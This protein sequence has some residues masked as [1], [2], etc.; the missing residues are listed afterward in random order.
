MLHLLPIRF[1]CA[2]LLY[3]LAGVG[4]GA[5]DALGLGSFRAAHTHLLAGGFFTLVIMGAMYQLL[6]TIIG[7]QLRY[8]RVAEAQFLLVNAGFLLLTYSFLTAPGMLTLSGALLFL[9]FLLFAFVIL[10]TCLSVP[11]FHRRSIAIWFFLAA[12]VYLLA[13]SGYALVS[14]LGGMEFNLPTHAHL[15]AAGFIAMTNFGGL[16]E[17]FPMLSLRQLHSRRLG[18]VHFLI[19]VLSATGMFLSFTGR[20]TLFY[21]SSALFLAGFYLFAYNMARTYFSTP[22][23][24][25][26]EMDISARFMA[27]ALVFGVAGVTAGFT[28]AVLGFPGSFTHAHLALAAWVGL[29]IVGAMYHIVPMLTWLEKYSSKVGQ[30]G[31]PL[32]QDLYHKP[33][34]RL[35][36]VTMNLSFAGFAFMPLLEPL[37]LLSIPLALAF[38]A[39][40]VEMFLVLRR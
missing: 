7:A 26:V 18:E 40:A 17:L 25:Q 27:Y 22:H 8:R 35:L 30:P 14:L 21:I 29:T 19:A 39:F 5:A 37:A 9:S 13:G 2:A 4:A 10:A 23:G 38:A 6:P 1:F 20:G 34:A 32:I 24:P 33:L 36:L 16:Y 31:V 12:V 11:G 28:T 3:M 15:L